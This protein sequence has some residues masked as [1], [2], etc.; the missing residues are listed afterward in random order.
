M[1]LDILKWYLV[2][3]WIGAIGFAFWVMACVVPGVYSYFRLHSAE[4]R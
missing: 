3:L 1:I 2:L 4:R